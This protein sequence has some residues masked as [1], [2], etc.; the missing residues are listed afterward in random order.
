MTLDVH[1]LSAFYASPLGESSRRLIQR[2]LQARWESCVGLSVLGL[3][4]C[5]PYLDRFRHNSERTLAFMPAQQGVTPWPL[6]G[7]CV[8]ALVNLEMLPLPDASIHRVLLIHALET[9]G[10]PEA[11][12]E[13]MGRVLTP[14]GRLILIVPS[15]RGLWAR[16]DRTPFGYGRPFSR[17]QLR[18]LVRDAGFSTLF[19]GE[20]LYAP[21]FRHHWLM[22]WGQEFERIGAALN[23]PFA[24]I[25]I[26]EV[27]KQ[28]YQPLYTPNARY[29]LRLRLK[30]SL[31]PI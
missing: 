24:G 23:L 27:I 7:D 17:S 5:V 13:E 10:H 11:V 4:Y 12:L 25:H 9:M 16:S 29:Q 26:V 6:E 31:A 15:R 14:E 22:K 1:E 20:A 30:S 18:D 8:T 19:W 3:G 21:P 28:V 2:V